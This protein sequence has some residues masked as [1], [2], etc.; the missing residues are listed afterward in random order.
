VT[1]STRHPQSA[2]G[3]VWK[4]DGPH[5]R[6][7]GFNRTGAGAGAHGLVVSRNAR[8]LYVANRNAGTI[9]VI[10]F[11]TTGVAICRQ[12][13]DF[14]SGYAYG[15]T[16]KREFR[17]PD[18]IEYACFAVE[19]T[20]PPDGWSLALGDAIHNL[21]ASLD[22]AVWAAADPSLRNHRSAFPVIK[23]SEKF[24]DADDPRIVGLPERVRSLVEAAQPFRTSPELPEGA[25]LAF[26]ADLSNAD[27]HRE[28]AT[29]AVQVETPGIGYEGPES[30]IKFTD[31]GSGRDL[32]DGA[33]VMGF[34]VTGPKADQVKVEPIFGYEVRVE[35]WPLR[36]SLD[37]IASAVWKSVYEC[38]TGEP[39]PIVTLPLFLL[40]PDRTEFPAAPFFPIPA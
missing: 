28:L 31:T 15:V 39:F 13:K 35:G 14:E 7:I 5:F 34:T 16:T 2:R 22:H 3:G 33:K 23:N 11:R 26:L 40:L 24:P 9:S 36:G 29:V 20:A 8:F 30:D 37:R 25:P 38:E 10:S 18:Q 12:V 1:H 17:H 27:K 21:R 19:R 6:I 4:L 32:R